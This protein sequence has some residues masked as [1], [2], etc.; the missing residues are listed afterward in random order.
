MIRRSVQV[1]YF[2]VLPLLVGFLFAAKNLILVLLTEKWLPAVPFAQIFCIA[3]ILMPIQ[4]INMTAIKSLG[5]SSITQKLEIYKKVIEAVILIVSFMINVYA[6]AWGIVLYDF[7]CIFINLYPCKKLVDYG[8]KEQVK[9]VLPTL[10]ASLIMGGVVYVC[11]YL[12]LNIYLVLSVQILVG[13]IVYYIFC[14]ILNLDGYEYLMM[15]AKKGMNKG[16]N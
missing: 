8:W 9:D 3:F 7:I 2:F 6:V 11:G 5:Y 13:T 16:K 10:A 12:P 4:N 14:R 15:Y 1:S